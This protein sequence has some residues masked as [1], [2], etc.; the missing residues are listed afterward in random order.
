LRLPERQLEIAS[1]SD[2]NRVA[3]PVRVFRATVRHFGGRA[4]MQAAAASLFD[5]AFPQKG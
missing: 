4:K 1:L 5:V 3:E 2:F